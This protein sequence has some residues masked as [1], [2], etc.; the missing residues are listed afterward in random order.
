M[1]KKLLATATASASSSLSFTSGIDSTYGVYEFHFINMHPSNFSVNWTFQVNAAGQTGFNETMT[2]T[3]FEATNLES[4]GAGLGYGTWADQAQ[5]T[6]YQILSDGQ[7]SNNDAGI[8]GVLTL[9]S[10]SS[11]TYVKHFYCVMSGMGS[12]PFAMNMFI[13]GYINT[14]SAID[15]IDFKFSSGNVD[16]GTIKMFGVS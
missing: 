4:G 10:P 5:G 14:T 16:A 11:T 12:S 13:A 3:F 8:S 15:E 1:A 2:T 7:S 9:F 6:G